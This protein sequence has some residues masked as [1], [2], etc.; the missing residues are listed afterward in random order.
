MPE[1]QFAEFKK[2]CDEMYALHCRKNNDYS[3]GAINNIGALGEKGIFVRIFDKTCRLLSLVW[4]AKE[5]K[6][7]DESIDDTIFDLATYAVIWLI[8]R[9]GTW[10]K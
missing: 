3:S 2:I 1:Q 9:R 8:Y 4:S 7:K 6:V 5:Q 10:G